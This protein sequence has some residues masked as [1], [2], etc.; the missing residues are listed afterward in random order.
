VNTWSNN[1][2]IKDL[3]EVVPMLETYHELWEHD[4]LQGKEM[5]RVHCA[6]D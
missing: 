2:D 6:L 4:V 1:T 5:S 3:R